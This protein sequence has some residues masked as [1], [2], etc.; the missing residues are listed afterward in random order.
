VPLSRHVARRF[1]PGERIEEAL[2]VVEDI[3]RQGMTATLDHL[4]ENVT[5]EAEADAE[6]SA[7]IEVLTALAG[8]NLASGV[9]VKLTNLGLD[10]SENKAVSN[11]RRIVEHAE[12]LKRFVR[13]DME[14]SAYVERTLSVYRRIRKDFRNVGIVL[15]SC[16]KRTLADAEALAREGI[17]DVRLVKGAYQEPESIAY[18]ERGRIRQSYYDILQLLWEPR[19]APGA[20][21]SAWRAT[22]RRS[23]AS[24][25]ASPGSGA[26]PPGLRVPVPL[27]RAP[28]LRGQDRVRGLAHAAVRALRHALVRLL[29][30]P[31]RRAARQHALR[32]P[33]RLREVEARPMLLAC[34]G[35]EQHRAC[36]PAAGRAY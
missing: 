5:S 7:Y 32:A 25:G 23:Q 12:P 17:A 2:T 8:R 19:R 21:A 29:H 15:Q 34:H 9:S 14:G 22:T 1:V 24:P 28:R 33:G 13:I 16:L 26:L 6:A 3:N 20:R 36:L 18:Q 30:A 31:H 4:G 27:R 35:P 10:F 11:L